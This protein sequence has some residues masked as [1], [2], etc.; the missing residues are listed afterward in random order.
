MSSGERTASLFASMSIDTVTLDEALRLLTLPRALGVGADGE[1]V[2]AQN[3]RYGPYIKQG[4]E[5]RSLESEDQL[6]TVTLD[7]ALALLRPAEDPRPP[8]GH[9]GR[10]AARSSATTRPPASRSSSVRAGS[11]RT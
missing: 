3:G 2:V 7:Q 6:F 5:S 4:K 10:P 8:V 1:E 9:A 11:G